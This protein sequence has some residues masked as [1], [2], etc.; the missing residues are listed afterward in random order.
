MYTLSMIQLSLQKRLAI[1][2]LMLILALFGLHLAASAFYWYVSIPWYDMMM[3]T[4]GGVFLAVFTAAFFYKH[5]RELNRY[6]TVVTLLLAVLVV[7]GMWEYF[8]YAVQYILK[9]S[10]ILA[11]FPDSVSDIVCDMVGGILGTLFVLQQKKRY[12]GTNGYD[13]E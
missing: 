5:S 7:G 4:L 11:K 9:G 6:E 10:I 1:S 3:H 12:N 2:S 13:I 8:E